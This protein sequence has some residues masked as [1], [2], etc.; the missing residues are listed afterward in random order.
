MQ[1]ATKRVRFAWLCGA[2]VLSTNCA[3][4]DRL[5]GTEDGQD[6]DDPIVVMDGAWESENG[7]VGSVDAEPGTNSST[8]EETVT[9]TASFQYVDGPELGLCADFTVESLRTD[10]CNWWFAGF[11]DNNPD[12]RSCRQVESCPDAIATCA[13]GGQLDGG[14]DLDVTLHFYPESNG[15]CAFAD[16]YCTEV[17]GT[18][19]CF[20][21]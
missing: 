14:D 11:C 5:G 7:A 13:Y 4:I 16:S 19:E 18:S 15:S 2:V 12:L 8:T 9:C 3:L 17:A 21:F 6:S 20:E 1:N 10:D